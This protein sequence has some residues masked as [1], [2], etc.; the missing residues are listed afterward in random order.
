LLA[1]ELPP[2]AGEWDLIRRKHGLAAPDLMAFAG[3]SLD[4][5]DLL[6]AGDAVRV[7]ILV[8]TVKLRR[9]G[10]SEM[11]DSEE[12]LRNAIAALQARK[13]LSPR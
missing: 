3:K 1:R 6:M 7:P 13:L 11:L 8:S 9:A 2:R 10:F 12:M 5:V 4:Y